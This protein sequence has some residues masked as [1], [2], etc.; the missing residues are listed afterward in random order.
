MITEH[1]FENLFH[2]VW[3]PP[4][5]ATERPILVLDFEVTEMKI[6]KV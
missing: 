1:V 3:I 4:C 6:F 2:Q 5:G